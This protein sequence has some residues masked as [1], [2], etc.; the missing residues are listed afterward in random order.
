[1]YHYP[2]DLMKLV[3]EFNECINNSTLIKTWNECKQI[4]FMSFFKLKPFYCIKDIKRL[5]IYIHLC[6]KCY[7]CL[8]YRITLDCEFEIL[9]N[10][11]LHVLHKVLHYS[12]RLN[13]AESVSL[14]YTTIYNINANICISKKKQILSKRIQFLLLLMDQYTVY[15]YILQF[16]KIKRLFVMYSTLD[17]VLCNSNQIFQ[18]Y[19]IIFDYANQMIVLLDDNRIEVFKILLWYN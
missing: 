14:V 10:M 5:K 7:Y 3:E 19:E 16:K 1:M 9:R 15:V 2:K 11:C 8:S 17:Y 4:Y 18:E 13:I 12:K 6:D